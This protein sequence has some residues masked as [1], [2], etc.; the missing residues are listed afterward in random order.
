[1]PVQE[2]LSATASSF[3]LIGLAEIGD[4][5]QLVCMA[6]AARHRHWPVLFGASLALI[7]LNALAVVFGAGITVIVPEK[8]AAGIVAALFTGFGIHFLR[9]RSDGDSEVI[10]AP[11]DRSL[12]M[13]A[14][15]LIFIAEFGDKTQIAVAG[16]AVSLSPWPVW[17]G[18][19]AALVLV[20][21][22][23]VWAGRTILRQLPMQWLHRIGGGVFLL[24]AVF[25]GWRAFA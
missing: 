3:V 15:L 19:S 9:A 24:F 20:S 25:A 13:T 4:K 21:C 7:L 6:L 23:G 16:L 2:F 22:L 1:M 11:T 17:A 5:S 12:F 8:I 18:A 10:S 14:F